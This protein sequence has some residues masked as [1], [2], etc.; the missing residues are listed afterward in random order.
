MPTSTEAPQAHRGSCLC[1]AVHY[2]VNGDLGA[3]IACHCSR[4][5]KAT[6][7]A[8]ATVVAVQAAD[9]HLE[10]GADQ[11]REFESSPGL[12]RVFCGQCGSPLYSRRPKQPELL[13]L[14]LG[15][16]DSHYPGSISA[17]IFTGSKADWCEIGGSAPQYPERP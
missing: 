15:T 13:R 8:F 7:T 16:L 17:H 4:C 6:G 12:F 3:A 11:L 14:R 1:G 2:H 10:R 5:R 9:L